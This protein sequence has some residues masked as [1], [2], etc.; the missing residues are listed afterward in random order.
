M[1]VNF[2]FS[3]VT[4]VE[5]NK[6][7]NQLNQRIMANVQSINVQGIMLNQMSVQQDDLADDQSETQSHIS[8]IESQQEGKVNPTK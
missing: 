1:L 7:V 2:M 4:L 3:D 5:F 8:A 6:V